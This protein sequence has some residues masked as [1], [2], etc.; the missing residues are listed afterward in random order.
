MPDTPA[1]IHDPKHWR[2]RANEARKLA[3]EMNDHASREAM[4][5]IAADYDRLA[6]RTELR[7][8]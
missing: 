8:K 6:E 2:A 5:R 7:A 3:A 4:L 1:T